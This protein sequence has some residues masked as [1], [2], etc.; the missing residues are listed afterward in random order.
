MY[1]RSLQKLQDE[2]LWFYVK[3]TFPFSFVREQWHQDKWDWESEREEAC[4]RLVHMHYFWGKKVWQDW[5]I[6][7]VLGHKFILQ[8]QPKYFATFWDNLKNIDFSAKLFVAT[9]GVNLGQ[10]LIP[11]SG[12]TGGEAS[13][14]TLK[15]INGDRDSLPPPYFKFSIFFLFYFLS[16]N[17]FRSPTLNLD[18]GNH[19]HW[20]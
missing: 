19:T 9:F 8:K 17:L 13:L 7:L 1:R 14:T 3:L 5:T 4:E 10:F 16:V 11:K 18:I 12:H 15:K 2:R 20:P 6:F